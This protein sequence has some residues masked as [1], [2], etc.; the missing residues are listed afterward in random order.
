MVIK[1]EITI[2]KSVDDVWEVLGNQ[3]GEIHIWAS[4]IHHSEVSGESKFDGVSYS[5]RSTDTTQGA[6]KQE[7]TSFDPASYS[8]SYAAISGM[9]FFIKNVNAT[10]A[11]TELNENSTKL[12]LNLVV[13]TAGIMGVILGP[14][15]KLKLGKLGDEL[16]DDFK[17]YV[18]N[19]KPHPRKVAAM[20]R[21]K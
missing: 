7:L 18:E 9:P 4:L 14:V 17:Y 16:L 11:L 19:G 21:D 13:E 15:A 2:S 6:T 3:F 10:W 8:L 12:N 1:K 5:I 20:S